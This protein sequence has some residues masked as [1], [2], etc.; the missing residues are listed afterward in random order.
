MTET[1]PSC[2]DIFLSH[3]HRS[4]DKDFVRQLAGDIEDKMYQDRQLWTWVDEAEIR[5]GQSVPAMIEKGLGMSRFFGIIMTPAYFHSESGW[6]DAEWHSALHQDP[7]NRQ[8]KIIPLLVEDCPFIPYLLKHLSV[9][10]FRYKNYRSALEKL[11]AV[12]REEPL[13]RPIAHRGQLITSGGQINRQTLISERA[14][15]QADPDVVNE[16]L[17][18]N[19]LPVEHLPKTVYVGRIADRLRKIRKHGTE[20][21]PTKQ[22]L[23]DEIQKAQM[24]AG[25]EKPFMPAF[26]VIE[27]NI[28]TFHDLEAAEN[29]FATVIEE[30]GVAP[31]QTGDWLLDEDERNIIT[32]LLNMALDRHAIRQGLVADGQR[33][34]K[35]F[36]FMPKN[37]KEHTVTW[38]PLKNKAGRTVAKPCYTSDG[39]LLFWRHLGAYLKM[40]Y[41]ADK[42]YLHLVPTWVLTEDG[43]QIRRGPR[44]GPLVIKW[45][46]KERNM[47]VLYHVRFWAMMLGKG[48]GPI[49]VIAGDQR[50][51]IDK[52]PAFIEQAYGIE[53]D[54]RDLLRQL[55]DEAALIEAKEEEL[56]DM[57]TDRILSQTEDR[58]KFREDQKLDETDETEKD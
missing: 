20:S 41:L 40:I 46:G 4:I 56:A 38:V 51:G 45:T 25:V 12:L 30:D 49:S 26:R 50:L 48:P 55:D 29:P 18:C 37:G 22:E 7:D 52:V 11:L 39:E 23:K 36:F 21:L 10:D 47:A 54:Q 57:E 53:Y 27:D 31:E 13:P 24:E 17:Y 32:S 3:S 43:Q 15:P 33:G 8:A 5:P 19:L 6:T 42:F 16:R 14:V 44:V 9:I 1:P 58:E 34:K 35:R 2:R 28:V